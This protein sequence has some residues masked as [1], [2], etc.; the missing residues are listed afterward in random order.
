MSVPVGAGEGEA[1]REREGVVMGA[2]SGG[3]LHLR[4]PTL[5]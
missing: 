1:M 3:D 4:N 2:L 5:L